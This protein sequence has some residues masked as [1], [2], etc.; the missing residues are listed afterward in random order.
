VSRSSSS[1]LRRD[2]LAIFRA[3]IEAADAARAVREHLSIRAGFLRAGRLRLPLKSFD[4][5]FLIAVGKAA[6]QMAVAVEGIAGS[7]LA[8]GLAITKHGHTTLRPRGVALIEAGHP[9]P[10]RAGVKA[11]GDVQEL[12]RELN[13]RDLLI[14]AISGGAS[15]LLSAP[16]EPVTL[17]A[18]QKTTDLLLRAGADIFQLNAVRKHL[19][20]LKGGQLAALA[21]PATLV[22]LL[23][24]DV[25][26]DPLDV[27]GSGPTAPDESTF[28]DAISVLNVYRLLERVPTMVR[29]RL[30]QGLRGE[31][32]ETPKPGDSLFQNVHNVVVGSN[33]LALQAAARQAKVLGYRPLIL[34]SSIQGETREVARVHG[35]ILREVVTSGHPL[36]A[37]ACLLSGGE[38]TVT[39]RGSGKGGR[40]QEFALA[41]A[42]NI[43]GLSNVLALSAGTD[44]TDGP[45]DA[46]GAMATGETVALAKKRGLDAL[47]HLT[48]NDAYPF[49]A[50]LGDLVKTGPTGT[51]VMDLN[52]LLAGRS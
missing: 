26:G 23:L 37:P 50:T 52:L 39:V 11:A 18:K 43:A 25:I 33:G 2:A 14:V 16:A 35:E 40:N 42:L 20:L 21:Y 10:D 28:A 3:A 22:S 41:A 27:I 31:I 12:L 30:G 49:F 6:A 32:P 19:S 29:E 4:R 1:R 17:A 48:R 36:R 51:N 45:T 8:G 7:Y 5:V 15:A 44:G 38:T 47:D 24:S 46:A 13:A 34:S 9:I